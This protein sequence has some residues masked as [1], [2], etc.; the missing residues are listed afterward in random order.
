MEKPL[1]L[2]PCEHGFDND[3][4]MSRFVLNKSYAQAVGL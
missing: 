3:M 2:V 4:H 1:I